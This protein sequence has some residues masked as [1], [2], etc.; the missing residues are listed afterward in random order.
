MQMEILFSYLVPKQQQH[1][2]KET[3]RAPFVCI[4]NSAR[5][6]RC[7]I[8]PERLNSNRLYQLQLNSRWKEVTLT[9]LCFL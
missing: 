2:T 7:H 9:T 5:L 6:S 3:S 8:I 1:L 4:N